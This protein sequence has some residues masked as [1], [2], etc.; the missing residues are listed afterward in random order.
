ML[1]KRRRV[2]RELFTEVFDKHKR[3]LRRLKSEHFSLLF[4]P[5]PNKESKAAVSVSKK[6][7]KSAVKRNK[8][9]RRAYSLLGDI[10]SGVK[11][12]IYFIN[13]HPGSEKLKFDEFKK[14]FESLFGN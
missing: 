3:E 12:G 6:V 5:T 13:T 8:V 14:E 4:F 10:L 1:K 7:S 11:P 2:P 9:R